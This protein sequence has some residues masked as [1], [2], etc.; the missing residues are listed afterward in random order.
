VLQRGLIRDVLGALPIVAL[1]AAV[2]LLPPDTSLSE[3]RTAGALRAC[4][5]AAHPPF[6]TGDPARPGI[7]VEI[8]QALARELGLTLAPSVEPAMN[9]DF[10][11]RSWHITRAACEL[12]AGGLAASPTTRSFLETSTPY[13]ET[14]WALLAPA[15]VADL[16]GR[17]LG[18]LAPTSGLDRIALASR[19]RAEAAQ[20]V[21]LADTDALIRGLRE[22]GFEAAVTER[23]LA[24][25]I[26]GREHWSADWLP[27]DLPR[28]PVALGLWKGD[29]TLKRAVNG[30]LAQ[31]DRDGTLN[32]IRARYLARP[33]AEAP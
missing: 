15:P 21:I 8:L 20:V 32:M 30:R 33:S 28:Y 12:I 31:L 3:V 17:K 14:G 5:P 26:A 23:F 18:V 2:Y 16:T 11:P 6:V 9:R 4:M 25:Q 27:G 19:L 13:A 24:E 1:L 29:L 10:N 7:D 22:G